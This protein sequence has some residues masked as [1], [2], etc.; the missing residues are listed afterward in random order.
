MGD[1]AGEYH[2]SN[3]IYIGESAWLSM[4]VVDQRES[5]SCPPCISSYPSGV[6]ESSIMS[7]GCLM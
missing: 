5:A 3:H 6:S 1:E 7:F 2:G 4:L